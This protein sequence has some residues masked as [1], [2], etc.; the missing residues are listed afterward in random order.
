MRNMWIAGVTA[1][2]WS[3][4]GALMLLAQLAGAQTS[5]GT[6]SGTVADNSGAV[7]T[8]AK[9]A[10]THTEAGVRRSSETNDAGIYRFDAVD[11]GLY[12]L[13]INHPGFRPFLATAVGVEANRTTSLDVRL[14]VGLVDAQ[15]TVSA[16]AEEMLVKDAPLRGGR[17]GTFRATRRG[18]TCCE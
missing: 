11:P 8:G 18:G 14:E 15:V 5:R 7:I 9:V 17:H 6:I 3:R 4:L 16:E 10:L 13:D 12:K 2:L 1:P